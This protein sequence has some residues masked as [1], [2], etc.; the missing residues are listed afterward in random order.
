MSLISFINKNTYEVVDELDDYIYCDYDIRYIIS[1]LN[2]KGYRTLFSCSG[3]LDVG[4][5]DYTHKEPIEELE[6]FLEEAKVDSSLHII[7][8]DD[9]Y[10]YHKDEKTYTCTYI[11]FDKVYDFN[12]LPK[13]FVVE[14]VDNKTNIYK[15]IFFYKDSKNTNR[16]SDQEILSE[17][18]QNY[19]DLKEWVRLLEKSI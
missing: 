12:V 1:E 4:L 2:R 11:S 7:K 15:K 19:E 13:D 3:H 9:K 17:L 16:K 14:V 18:N 8:K 5:L 10:F 6:D